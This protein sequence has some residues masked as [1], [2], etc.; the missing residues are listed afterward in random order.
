[1]RDSSGQRIYDSA[2]KQAI[3]R[4]RRYPQKK[5]LH[6]YHFVT[7]MTVDIDILEMRTGK[8]IKCVGPREYAFRSKGF[9]SDFASALADQIPRDETWGWM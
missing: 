4:A 9:G 2:M 8:V 6:I 3:G 5:H 1:M 7:A